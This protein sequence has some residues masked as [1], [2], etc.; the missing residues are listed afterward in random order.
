MALDGQEL[1]PETVRKARALEMDMVQED[2]CV[3]E[4]PFEECFEKTTRPPTKVKRIDHNQSD[5]Q[6]MN[7]WSSLVAKRINRF[8]RDDAPL[9]ASRMLPSATVAGHKHK[10]RMFNDISRAYTH[11]R[12]A[13]DMCVELCVRRI[14][15]SRDEHRCG[16]LIKS[17]Y[18]TRAAAHDWQSEVTGTMKGSRGV[19]L[20][21][22]PQM[23][24][25]EKL[26][27]Q[28]GKI[29][30]EMERFNGKAKEEDQG[31]VALV[32]DLAKAFERVS[33][34]VVWAWATHFSFPTKI[35]GALRV[36][37]A[38]EACTVRRM[39]G[40]A[41]HLGRIEVELFAFAHCIAGCIE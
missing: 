28:C 17:V 10:V 2:A 8:V 20:I 40:R 15:P 16:K 38:P 30:M 32:L 27:K 11:A 3:R 35:L 14:R 12:M 34:L 39:C 33:L 26:S 9:E 4:G 24:E 18:G 1:D 36:L 6:N 23:A 37:R 31:E 13:S 25:M 41:S 21:G 29:L 22:T 7:V 19:G 5:R